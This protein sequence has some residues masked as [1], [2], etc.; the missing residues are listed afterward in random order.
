QARKQHSKV[1]K[2]RKRL[3]RKQSPRRGAGY[4]PRPDEAPQDGAPI[5]PMGRLQ[6]KVLSVEDAVRAVRGAPEPFLV[7]RDVDSGRVSVV[8]RR[9]DGRFGCLEM[10]T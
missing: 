7:F 2:E 1:S 5:V 3:G 6:V 10:E 8:F 9:R 4:E